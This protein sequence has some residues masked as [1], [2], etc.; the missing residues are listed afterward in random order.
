[1]TKSD[2]L[3]AAKVLL[4]ALPGGIPVVIDDYSQAASVLVDAALAAGHCLVL[5]PLLSGKLS[6]QSGARVAEKVN[7][8]VHVRVNPQVPI[9]AYQLHDAITTA[10]CGT[11]SFAAKAGTTEGDTFA[12]V[13]DDKGLF[14]HSLFYHVLTTNS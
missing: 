12:L 11:L 7:F 8:S 1:M 4:E 5:R 2:I 10:L 14:T 3:P 13:P 6:S 9:A